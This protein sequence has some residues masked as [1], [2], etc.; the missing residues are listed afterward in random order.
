MGEFLAAQPHGGFQGEVAQSVTCP[1]VAEQVVVHVLR[2]ALFE[3]IDGVCRMVA[4]GEVGVL[5]WVGEVVGAIGVMDADDGRHEQGID[6]TVG[7]A[8]GEGR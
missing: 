5:V 2:H 4:N 3:V 6:E 1:H 7:D 8:G